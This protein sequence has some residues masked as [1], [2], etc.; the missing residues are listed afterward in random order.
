MVTSVHLLIERS[1]CACHSPQS[2]LK[3]GET[4]F[5]SSLSELDAGIVTPHLHSSSNSIHRSAVTT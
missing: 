1:P 5:I 2:V 3:V 4:P